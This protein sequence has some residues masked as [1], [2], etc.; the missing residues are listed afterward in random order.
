MRVT[1][2][3]SSKKDLRKHFLQMREGLSADYRQSL[4]TEIISRLLCSEVYSSAELILT[5]VSVSPEINTIGLI[6]AAFANGKKVA[7]PL[8]IEGNNMKFYYIKSTDDLI[9]G[10]YGLLEP[11]TSKC[12]E[13]VINDKTLCVVPGLSF[14]ANGMRL[15]R[16]GGYYDRFLEHF[17]G[18]SVGLCYASFMRLELPVQ[19]FDKAVDIIVTE[20]F[21][22]EVKV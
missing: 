6:N 10:K 9:K 17:K 20:N 1:D 13:A 12:K 3:K 19:S 22:R 18:T 2:E 16:G 15:G 4:D 7:V 21:L 8:C 14:D 11:D 5:Y